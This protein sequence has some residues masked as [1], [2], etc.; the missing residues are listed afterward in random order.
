MSI[1]LL[2][3]VHLWICRNFLCTKDINSFYNMYFANIFSICL[4][5]L[6]VATFIFQWFKY[7]PSQICQHFPLWLQG[8]RFAHKGLCYPKTYFKI[9]YIF[10]YL[11]GFFT[12]KSKAKINFW[13]LHVVSITFPPKCMLNLNLTLDFLLVLT[14][15]LLT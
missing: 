13:I 10:F 6:F 1:L 2:G 15:L 8:F 14:R 3:Y 4:L 11:K 9:S 5:N 7:F 12:L